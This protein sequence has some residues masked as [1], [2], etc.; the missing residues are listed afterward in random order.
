MTKAITH[1]SREKIV[2]W[3]LAGILLLSVGF[4]MF[5]IN[6]TVRN[7]VSREKLEADSSKLALE[8]SNKEFQYISMRNAITFEYAETL[9]FKEVSQKTFLNKNSTKTVSYLPKEM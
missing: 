9:G 7:V 8:I 4:Y 3:I 1:L 6:S 2:F 5:C